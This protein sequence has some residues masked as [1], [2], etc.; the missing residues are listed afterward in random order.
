MNRQEDRSIWSAFN[1]WRKKHWQF[2]VT[3]LLLMLVTLLIENNFFREP[4]M[5]RLVRIACRAIEYSSTPRVVN[6]WMYYNR[7][8]EKQ[9]LQL[10]LAKIKGKLSPATLEQLRTKPSRAD[11]TILFNAAKQ[12]GLLPPRA[13]LRKMKHAMLASAIYETERRFR[14][15][16]NGVHKDIDNTKRWRFSSFEKLM[17]ILG[18]FIVS[19]IMFFFPPPF[20]TTMTWILIS[21]ASGF[22]TY[23]YVPAY[24]KTAGA[25][26]AILIT[27]FLL[28]GNQMSNGLLSEQVHHMWSFNRGGN[29][30]NI[31]TNY[32][33]YYQIFY[34]VAVSLF[35]SGLAEK[36]LIKFSRRRI[37]FAST[38]IIGIIILFSGKFLIVNHVGHGP[39][40]YWLYYRIYNSTLTIT[41]NQFKDLP[42]I[43]YFTGCGVII[44]GVYFFLIRKKHIQK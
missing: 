30:Y 39:W 2:R 7:A 38:L 1:N 25:V 36:Y 8:C 15:E 13:D 44:W 37:D 26:L 16:W 6:A 29:K 14:P 31:L 21:M 41:C 12:H 20:M 40:Y 11:L 4:I 27:V 24:K 28:L 19:F 34:C 35:G 33:F 10:S 3:I 18:Y 22:F 5:H 42:Y 9:R 23:A 17:Q 32:F 43:L